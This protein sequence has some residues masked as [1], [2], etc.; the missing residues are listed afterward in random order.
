MDKTKGA[1][2]EVFNFLKLHRSYLDCRKL[3]RKTYNALEFE[4]DIERNLFSLLE[5]LQSKRYRPGRSVCFVVEDP[6]YRE[7]FAADFRDRIVHHLLIREV[8]KFGERKFIFNSFSCRKNKGTHIGVKRLKEAV[9]KKNHQKEL[10][11]LQ[12]DISGFFMAINHKILYA[13]FKKLVLK[14]KKSRKWKED[15]LW[16][17]KVIIFHNPTKN[18]LKK[19]DKNLFLKVPKRKS[20]FNSKKGSGL[21][22][23]NYS[24]QFFANLYLDQLDQFV[25]RKLRCKHYFRYVDDFILLSEN[26]ENLKRYRDQVEKFLGNFLCLEISHKKTKIQSVEKGIDFLGYFVKPEVTFSRQRVVKNIKGKLNG[27]SEKEAKEKDNKEKVI[28][29]VNSYLGHFTHSSSRKLRKKI[30]LTCYWKFNILVGADFKKVFRKKEKVVSDKKKKLF[31]KSKKDKKKKR[32]KSVWEINRE[33]S[34]MDKRYRKI[35]REYNEYAGN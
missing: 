32:K 27:F 25:K 8:E 3:K 30:C 12:M 15:V 9:R 4:I 29:M 6:V 22:I 26:K 20:L 19:G 16:L 28:A 7:I 23:G 2:S 35:M 17:A 11:Y 31:K 13:I 1:M 14:Q 21:P 33:F 18:Y 10:Y 5:D 24:S 34:L